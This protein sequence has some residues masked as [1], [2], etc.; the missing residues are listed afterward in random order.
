MTPEMAMI[1]NIPSAER[2][3]SFGPIPIEFY[4]RLKTSVKVKLPS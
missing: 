3:A 2:R 4:S 1:C